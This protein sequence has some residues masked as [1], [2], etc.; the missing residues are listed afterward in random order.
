MHGRSNPN[1]AMPIRKKT[2]TSQ[3]SKFYNVTYATTQNM[4]IRNIRLMSTSEN[5]ATTIDEY[6]VEDVNHSVGG[7]AIKRP[8]IVAASESPSF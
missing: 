8:S 6:E 1:V 7:S 4:H 5:G 2:N 3:H